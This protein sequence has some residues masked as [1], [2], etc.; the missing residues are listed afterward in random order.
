MFEIDSAGKTVWELWNPYGGGVRKRNTN[1]RG[2][3][4]LNRRLAFGVWRAQK[5]QA[6]F[7]GLA[8][9]ELEPISPQPDFF[10]LPP[11]PPEEDE[12]EEAIEAEE[13]TPAP[14]QSGQ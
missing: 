7:P 10:E 6:D 9:R 1:G 11:P 14:E 12:E 3:G 4:G 13:E 2:G 5:Y 8:D